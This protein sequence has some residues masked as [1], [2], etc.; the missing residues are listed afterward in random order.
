MRG[1]G[2]VARQSGVTVPLPVLLGMGALLLVVLLATVLGRPDPARPEGR[3][4]ISVDLRFED[5]SDGGVT[6][7]RA[8]DGTVAAVLAP[9]TEGFIRATLRGL[10]RER[11]GNGLGPEMPFRLSTWPDGRF[12]LE[13]LATGRTLDLRAFGST[14]AEAFARLLPAAREERR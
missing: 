7:R 9:G 13:D 1:A 5:Q 2:A 3:A 12:S 6:V 11:R 4:L 14:Q 10:A 8:D